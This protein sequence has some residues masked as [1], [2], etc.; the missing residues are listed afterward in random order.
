MKLDEQMRAVRFWQ[1]AAGVKTEARR[2]WTEVSGVKRIESVADHSFGVAILSLFEAE[3][4]G[5]NLERTLKLALIHDLEEAMTGDLT[6]RDKRR[7][8]SRRVL[9]LKQVAISEIL[10]LLP[11]N[12]RVEYRALWNDLT[13]RRTREARLVKDLDR[14]EMACQ[15]R[16]YETLGVGHEQLERFYSSAVSQIKDPSLKKTARRLAQSGDLHG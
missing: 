7:L 5:Y 3:R 11:A 6:P 4:R 12:R 10:K 2:G 15:A 9:H 16:R 8:S 13:T 1:L 14:L